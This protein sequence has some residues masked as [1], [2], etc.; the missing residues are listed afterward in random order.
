[1]IRTRIQRVQYPVGQG[2]FHSCSIASTDRDKL[3][4]DFVF[5]YVY[6][7]GTYSLAPDGA[8][9]FQHI[10]RYIDRYEPV[11]GKVDLL[12]LSHLDA[13][14]YNGAEEL[15][16]SKAVARIVLPYFTIEEVCF[17]VAQQSIKKHT[18]PLSARYINDLLSL[19]NGGTRLFGAPVT[20]VMPG[21]SS[22]DTPG[23]DRPDDPR[24]LPPTDP[25]GD[26]PLRAVAC[27]LGPHG[28]LMPLGDGIANGSSICLAAPGAAPGKAQVLPVI[29]R[30]WSYM[31]SPA[32]VAYMR[33][34]IA[35]CTPL[36]K[37]LDRNAKVT[38]SDIAALE[39][40]KSKVRIACHDIIK[41]AG[42][43]YAGSE[44]HPNVN[45]PS[46][47]LYSG[48]NPA[49]NPPFAAIHISP[50]YPCINWI[51]TGDAL[52][53]RHWR[54]FEACFKD[55]LGL[56][57]TYVVPHHG[58]LDNHRSDFIQAVHPCATAVISSGFGQTHHPARG[59]LADIH[60]IGH[61]LAHVT[62]FDRHGSMQCSAIR[63]R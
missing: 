34:A 36:A 3:I 58:S 29:L 1:M 20:R 24:P 63:W 6:D 40:A 51:A 26:A 35:A 37:L 2:G 61:E 47:C 15:C 60:R 19:A 49:P 33:T 44:R 22:P 18:A 39:K 9:R 4:P 38:A 52:L 28:Q 17:V 53:K 55:V 10:K 31:Q 12:F 5:D 25:D 59:V 62:E 45:S 41:A 32:A 27:T 54:E 42:G 43:T 13:D 21:G 30:P 46:L 56:T 50:W 23:P 16:A 48:I 11:D 7:C 14:H 57:G 8:S